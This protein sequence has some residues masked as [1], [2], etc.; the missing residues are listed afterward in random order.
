MFFGLIS[1]A[2]PMPNYCLTSSIK[3]ALKN[4]LSG[5]TE[6]AKK[7]LKAIRNVQVNRKNAF[8]IHQSRKG[9][10]LFT[11]SVFTQENLNE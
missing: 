3:R 9:L 11:Q 4:N 10:F 6:Y 8:G 1:L 5:N 2:V 7:F